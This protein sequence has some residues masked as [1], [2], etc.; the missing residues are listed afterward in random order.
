MF[1]FL[2]GG[3]VGFV[4]G[5]FVPSVL[6]KLKALFVKEATVIKTDISKKL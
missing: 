5:A 1:N 6:R 3:G 2:L 4:A